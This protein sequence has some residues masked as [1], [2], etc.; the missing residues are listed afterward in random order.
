MRTFATQA[1]AIWK[2]HGQK[3]FDITKGGFEYN[4]ALIAI[5]LGLLVAG[6][7]VA[8]THEL[9]ERRLEGRGSR[10]LWS[11][12]RPSLWLRLVKLLK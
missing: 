3:G 11:R 8:S 9:L 1:V 10:K 4:L 12:A 2:V 6:P 5:A 7:G